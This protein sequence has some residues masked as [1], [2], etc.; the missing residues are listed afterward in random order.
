MFSFLFGKKK[1]SSR[2]TIPKKFIKLARKYKVKL[3]IKKGSKKVPKKLSVLK[4]EIKM[5]MKSKRKTPRR[6]RKKNAF[7]TQWRSV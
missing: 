6:G 5:K 4:K 2:K 3:F 7:W 1:R